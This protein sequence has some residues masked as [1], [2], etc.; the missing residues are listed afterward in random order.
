MTT[1]TTALVKIAMTEFGEGDIAGT[2]AL[3]DPLIRWDDRA[4]DG[5][6]QLVLGQE[7]VLAHLGRW[8]DGWEEYSAKIEN[9]KEIADG[10]VVVSY[11]ESGTERRTGIETQ[12]HR[13]AAVT[14]ERGAITSWARYLTESEAAGAAEA[15]GVKR[16]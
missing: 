3:A 14:V 12:Q 16:F 9:L 7:D 5:D 10:R 13:A 2:L 1:A 6:G 11:T 15:S 4:L 8:M